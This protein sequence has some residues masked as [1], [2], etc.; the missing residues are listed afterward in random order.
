MRVDYD[1][2]FVD[3]DYS[4][5]FCELDTYKGWCRCKHLQKS[6]LGQLS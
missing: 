3:I 5:A 4:H 2:I 6:N 1:F